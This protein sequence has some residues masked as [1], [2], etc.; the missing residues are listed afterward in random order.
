MELLWPCLSHLPAY[1]A[2]LERGW[3]PDNERGREAAEDELTRIELSPSNFVASLVDLEGSG[4][5][6]QLPDG[7]L[8]P[9]L[10]GYR[11]WIW[12]GTFCGSI[13]LRWHPQGDALPWYCLGHVGY[14]VVP[15]KQRRGYATEALALMLDE[16]RERGL[17]LVELTTDGANKASQRVIHANGGAL[18]G[19]E[20]K[21]AAFRGGTLLRFRIPL[22]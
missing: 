6:V 16:A 13:N 5:P 14:S 19:E 1:V 8:V 17:P 10:P 12:D 4:G 7:S 21:P 22:A 20:A 3:T 9:R 18:L 11:K 15:W 2:A